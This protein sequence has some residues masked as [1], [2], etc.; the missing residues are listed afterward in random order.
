ME[1]KEDRRTLRCTLRYDGAAFSGWQV[2]PNAHTVQGLLEDAFSKISGTAIR[3]HGAGRTDAGVHALAQVFHCEWP[4]DASYDRLPRAIAGMSKGT[5][6]LTD[7]VEVAPDFHARFDAVGKHY[8]YTI[9]LGDN[10]D[11]LLAPYSWFV[12][13]DTDI[14]LIRSLCAQVE[15]V[16]D[17]AGFQCSG[18][19][20][21]ST[22]REIFSATVLDGPVIGPI[23]AAD[24]YRIVFHGSGF[25]Y[26]MVRNLAGTLVDIARGH[27]PPETLAQ[28]LH[29][30]GPYDGY[31][32]PARGLCLMKVDY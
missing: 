22:E 12:P 8:G 28:R 20:V 27:L 5:I 19:D 15:G 7:V 10:S 26:K 25:L 32:A 2:Q 29:A 6:L 13:P 17:F 18:N 3:I 4:R 9:A 31:T 14:E 16:H 30:V 23:D 24:A 1:S 11:P 21:Q